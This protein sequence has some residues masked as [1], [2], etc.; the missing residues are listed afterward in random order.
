ML[1]SSQYLYYLFSLIAETCIY[2][3]SDGSFT[4]GARQAVTQGQPFEECG[5][6]AKDYRSPHK[7]SRLD[8]SKYVLPSVEEESLKLAHRY[9]SDQN[10]ASVTLAKLQNPVKQS[11]EAINSDLKDVYKGLGNYSKALDKVHSTLSDHF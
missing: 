4:R 1:V 8:S 10:S 2:A 11:F 5:R 3:L 6:C 9:F 7:S